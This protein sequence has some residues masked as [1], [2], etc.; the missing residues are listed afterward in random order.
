MGAE[1]LE[2]HNLGVGDHTYYTLAVLGGGN[3]PSHVCSVHILDGADVNGCGV[4]VEVPAVDIIDV[5]IAVIIQSVAGNLPRIG[6]DLPGQVSVVDIH[7][8]IHDGDENLRQALH[9]GPALRSID[10]HVRDSRIAEDRLTRVL[11]PPLERPVEIGDRL[12]PV[13]VVG[14]D[15]LDLAA[16]LQGCDRFGD[17]A[18]APDLDQFRP[19]IGQ[20]SLGLKILGS[21][22]PRRL[23]GLGEP[24]QEFSLHM[25]PAGPVLCHSD[26][27]ATSGF[28]PAR[29]R[30][31]PSGAESGYG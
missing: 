7:S 14:L 18:A 17:R 16:G 9:E 8:G 3:G 21:P 13:D 2:D 22:E 15:P 5:A 27:H 10:I 4:V 19:A 25:T 20:H 29:Y 12:S 24:D 31:S 1:D 11:Q 26:R 23:G 30:R 28:P 6:P